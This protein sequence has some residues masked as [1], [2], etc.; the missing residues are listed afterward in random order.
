MEPY[1]ELEYKIGEWV[2]TNPRNVVVCS[3]GTAALHLAFAALNLPTGQIICPEY[4]MVACPRAIA[5]AG[6]R[7]VFVDCK[8]DLQM[9]EGKVLS[10]RTEL[11]RAL[12]VVHIYGRRCNM[13]AL[14]ADC[15]LAG[16]PV[17]EDMAE[18]HGCR[19]HPSSSAA[20]YSFYRNK[21]VA[22]EEG[23]CVIFKEAGVADVARGM[24]SHGFT[25]AHNYWHTAFGVNYRLSNANASLI[26]DSL[27]K[28][29]ENLQKR[30][31]IE[32][33]Y[34]DLIPSEWK[35]P[36]RESVWVYDVCLPDVGTANPLAAVVGELNKVGIQ[37]RHGFKPMSMQPEF[38]G[39]YE[40]LLATRLSRQVLY[41][42]VD[43]RMGHAD[44]RDNVK[45]LQQMVARHYR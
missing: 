24:R 30:R 39:H 25:E 33:W 5:M 6:H 16:Y 4:T 36:K 11:T 18:V 26:L 43:P 20:C 37:A 1:L 14:S 32:F 42:P 13:R 35:M 12:L 2:E 3:S 23:G 38:R 29:K 31:E 15:W 8:A 27:A 17:I 10:T 22:G 9:H 41:L 34:D 40:H 7:P 21:V 45:A 44:V 28:V 19:P